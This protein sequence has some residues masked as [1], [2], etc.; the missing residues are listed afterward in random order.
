[1]YLTKKNML[2]RCYKCKGIGLVKRSKTIECN[3]CTTQNCS[4]CEYKSGTG[5]YEECST[6][7]GSGQIDSNRISHVYRSTENIEGNKSLKM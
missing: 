5:L 4:K 7:W 6:C 1:M 3:Y 2:T